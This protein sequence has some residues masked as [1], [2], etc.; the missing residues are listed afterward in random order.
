MSTISKYT[1]LKL[2]VSY[3]LLLGLMAF[4]VWYL[5]QQQSR[6]HKLVKEDNLDKKKL[7]YTEL[8]RDLYASDRLSRVALQTK[9]KKDVLTFI[10][11]NEK[12]NNLLDSLEIGVLKEDKIVIDSLQKNL[13][14]KELNVMLLIELQMKTDVETSINQV[15]NKIEKIEAQKE[16]LKVESFFKNTKKLSPY[17]RKMAKEYAEYLNSKDPKKSISA[18]EADSILNLSKR[19][20]RESQ[21]KIN[22]E[23][24]AIKDKEV[25]LLQNELI[26]TQKMSDLIAKIRQIS[27]EKQAHLAI[28]KKKSQEDSL[29]WMRMAAI[30][31]VL[32]VVFFFVLLSVDFL[33]NKRYRQELELQKK[34]T[35]VLLE[36]REQLMATVSHD[37]KTPL[38]SLVGYTAQ[39]LEKESLFEKRERLLK[40]KS[41][42]HYIE[43]LVLDLLDY[44]RMEKGKIKLFSQEFDFNELI[45]ETGQNIADLHQKEKIELLYDIEETEGLVYY[46]DY[47]KIRQILYNLV[48]NAFK[49]TQQGNITL[50]TKLKNE[51][52]FISVV[53]TGKGIAKEAF[54]KIFESFTQENSEIEVLYG[55][56][57][58][59]LSIC[60]RLVD[61]LGG[62]IHVSSE[63]GKGSTFTFEIPLSIKEKKEVQEITDLQIGLVLDDDLAQSQL[64]S[65]LL[66]S[67]FEE[68]VVFTD[69]SEALSYCKE[70]LPSVVITDIH[71]P[72][73][74]G[75]AFLT[76]LR[77]LPNGNGV[78]VI[79]VSGEMPYEEVIN[80]SFSFDSFLQKPYSSHQL[81]RTI[82]AVSGQEI[83]LNHQ[84]GPQ[85]YL[86]LLASFLGDD[87]EVINAF[88]NHYVEELDKD[89]AF[90]ENHFKD[91][92][93]QGIIDV[94]HKMQTMVS[95]LQEKE[96]SILLGVI[97]KELK[98]D[99]ELTESVAIKIAKALSKLHVFKNHLMTVR[100][101]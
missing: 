23:E 41:A 42:T 57:G 93:L 72:K 17:E 10:K 16:K 15:V 71:M 54:E 62:D 47:N 12:I 95:Q 14:E 45:E 28:E 30:I 22:Q 66:K 59:G 92:N 83:I 79:G 25:Q 81:L 31:C 34:R 5:F 37:V 33:K 76:Q 7:A 80:T 87:R 35:E 67:Y 63:L 53:D 73:M 86:P 96:L 11:N 68:V 78:K 19:I 44:V 49:F 100:I 2:L 51:K 64:V 99:P 48:G 61:L 3:L 75:Y 89:T 13:K 9:K 1:S 18:A 74:N 65:S 21:K 20:L 27:E 91:H 32:V 60:K 29:K 56:T 69:G 38:Q 98:Q 97:E 43:Q 39:L 101:D 70:K 36:S 4:A 40:I 84:K 8:I 77:K 88:I 55:G 26:I 90:F 24:I 58:L 6:L 94:C 52:L 82:A 85:G 50:K 46:G